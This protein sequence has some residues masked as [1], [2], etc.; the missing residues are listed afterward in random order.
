MPCQIKVIHESILIPNELTTQQRVSRVRGLKTI[1]GNLAIKWLLTT[2]KQ[3]FTSAHDLELKHPSG[4]IEHVIAIIMSEQPIDDETR[5]GMAQDTI[6]KEANE[7][8]PV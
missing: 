1:V 3:W 5:N 8:R 6:W 4:G 2:G 7:E